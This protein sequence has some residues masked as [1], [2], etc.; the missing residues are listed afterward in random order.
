MPTL[1]LCSACLVMV[2]LA[3]CQEPT[4]QP[5][6]PLSLEPTPLPECTAGMEYGAAVRASGGAPPYTFLALGLPAG[7]LFDP[8]QGTLSGTPATDG[9]YQVRV[10]VMD[11]GGAS[12]WQTY[13]LH[14]YPAPRLEQ[15]QLPQ[16]TAGASYEA[17]LAIQGGKAPL[18][19]RLERGPLPTGLR[20]DASRGMLLGTPS[21]PG[22]FPLTFSVR[23]GHGAHETRSFSLIISAPL[24]LLGSLPAGNVGIGYAQA[25]IV[26]GGRAP[27]QLSVESGTLPPGLSLSAGLLSGTPTAGGRF[28]FVL[29][30]MDA[31]GAHVSLPVSLD[32]HSH[33]PPRVATTSLPPATLGS[34]YQQWLTGAEGIP[35]YTFTLTAG[36][37]PSGLTLSAEGRLGGTAMALEARAFQVLLTDSRGQSTQASFTLRTLE[38][39]QVRTPSL[40]EGYRG[41]PYTLA[42]QSSGGEPPYRWQASSPPPLGL[43]L[44]EQGVLAGTPST[45]GSFSLACTLTDAAGLVTTALLPLQVLE[46]PGLGSEPLA[47]GYVGQPYEAQ[48]TLTGG[49]APYLWTVA[50]GQLP[51]GVTLDADSGGLS[52]TP[53]RAGNSAFSLRVQDAHRREASRNFR[54][55]VYAPPAWETLYLLPEGV[56][57]Q[58]YAVNLTASSGRPPLRFL[59]VSGTLPAGLSLSEEGVLGPGLHSSLA[60]GSRFTFTLAVEDANGRSSTRTFELP[61][62][63]PLEIL[64]STLTRAT[65][66]VSY[67]R[68]VQEP[69]QVQ[70]RN[71]RQPLSWSAEGLPTGLRLDAATGVLSGIPSQDAAGEHSVTFIVADGAG[72]AARK[73]LRLEVVEP[74]QLAGGGAVGLP[75]DGSPITDVLTVFVQGW[76]RMPLQGVGVRIRRNGQ[77]YSPPKQALTDPQGKVVFT[78]LGL[79]GTSDTVDVT[80]NGRGLVTTTLAQMN[81]A[82]LTVP[83]PRIAFPGVREDVASAY[84]PGSGRFL[85]MGGLAYGRRSHLSEFDVCYNDVVSLEWRERAEFHELLPSGLASAPVPRHGASLAVKNGVAVYFGGRTCEVFNI[86]SLRGTLDD[87]WELDLRNRTWISRGVLSPVPSARFGA[88]MVPDPTANAVILVGG[89]VRGL[90]NAEVWRYDLTTRAWQALSPAPVKGELGATVDETSRELWFCE[91]APSSTCASFEPLASTWTARPLLPEPLAFVRL[92]YDPVRDGIYALGHGSRG[93]TL[94]WLQRGGSMWQRLTPGVTPD[95]AELGG[96]MGVAYFDRVQGKLV[97]VDLGWL[98][99]GAGGVWLFDGQGWQPR[100]LPTPHVTPPFVRVRGPL[101]GTTT[102]TVTVQGLLASGEREA[103]ERNFTSPGS[104]SYELGMLP[105]EEPLLISALWRDPSFTFP[106]HL[107]SLVQVR[108]P[109]RNSDYDLPLALPVTPFSPVQATGSVALPAPW[110]SEVTRATFSV[111]QQVSGH[112]PATLGD[113][114]PSRGA[115]STVFSVGWLPPLSTEPVSLEARLSSEDPLACESYGF[116]APLRPG[117]NFLSTV[118]WGITAASPGVPGCIPSGA[119]GIG[120]AFSRASIGRVT[121][122]ARG[123]LDGD[124]FPDVIFIQSQGNH[125]YIPWGRPG[126]QVDDVNPLIVAQLNQPE[127]ALMADLNLDGREDL[128]VAQAGSPDLQVFS[129]SQSTPRAFSQRSPLSLGAFQARLARVDLG[130]PWPDLLVSLPERNRVALLRGPVQSASPE[131]LPVNGTRPGDLLVTQLDGDSA[132]DLVVVVA[133]GLSV[134]R[135]SG[136]GFGEPS[137]LRTTPRPAGVV[138]AQLNGRGPMDLAVAVGSSVHIFLDGSDSSSRV[139]TLD[140][141]NELK[142]IVA[143]EFTRDGFMDL[144]VT[145]QSGERI[146]VLQGRADGTFVPYARITARD[147]PT[148]MVVTDQN[149]DGLS[150]I[151]VASGEP[152]LILGRRPLPVVPGG[153]FSFTAPEGARFMAVEHST[154]RQQPFWHYY[155]P[156]Q[157]GR[158]TYTL[159]QPSTLACERPP[160]PAT[161]PPQQ[162]QWS[163]SPKVYLQRSQSSTPF[164]PHHFRLQALEHTEW[165]QLGPRAYQWTTP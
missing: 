61:V 152:L 126:S 35:P 70:A 108:L 102:G 3:A 82:V 31:N 128:V 127:D 112:A 28:T 158:I 131:E 110:R 4:P 11:T 101:T 19:L 16:A 25:L 132:P 140:G 86:W 138:A 164:N 15:A 109:P 73:T 43:T 71:G 53:A 36:T 97:A 139:W 24:Q 62:V 150:D 69:E 147:S 149:G 90:A 37:L 130:D 64:T 63:A 98:H 6:P 122:L 142:G 85:M 87:T 113:E 96:F 12:A 9:P 157:A 48:P 99:L 165:T 79:N 118:G 120:P 119:Q 50:S 21:E 105:P 41:Q 161:Y 134:S 39:L 26:S 52:G 94:F 32:I 107:R 30:V 77:E 145:E 137:L 155:A 100:G 38:G 88:A 111:V 45:A 83:V 67:R 76:F 68:S 74:R 116:L 143:A 148:Q 123:D 93:F 8:S 153:T 27:L 14:V 1:R 66:G 163:W 156:V 51:P 34:P 49:K 58:P 57:G 29:R 59:H 84:D 2:L 106:Y 135:G 42:L 117:L 91:Q 104:S 78:G 129:G 136:S 89:Q 159:P 92:V 33:L 5:R 55:D 144:A 44:S 18:T 17:V 125:I 121:R 141:S 13:L 40:P 65:E 22:T 23:D 160:C 115:H 151:W 124:S 47:D 146:H 81:A 20:F 80:V 95:P 46:L 103:M 133:E 114:D 60:P 10:K 56:T 162:R 154:H 54:I 75:P 72:R 7:V